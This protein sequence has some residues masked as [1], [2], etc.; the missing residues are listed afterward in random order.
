M[1][2]A[3]E[4]YE[5][6]AV[7]HA[8]SALEPEDE[9]RFLAHLPG[10]AA[11]ERALA[12][13]T[14]TLAH[15]A[16][17][18]APAEPPASLLEGIRSG[19]AASGRA[20][21]FPAPASLDAARVRRRDRTVRWTTAVLGAAAA[22]VLVVALV[23]VNRGLSSREHDAQVANARLS[24]AVSSLLVSGARRV[25]LAGHGD[26]KAVAVLH[27]STVSLVVAGLP[28]NDRSNSVYVLWEK[29]RFGDVRAVGTFDVRSKALAVV[30]G[31]HL[32]GAPSELSTLMVTREH[33]RSAPAL[34][35]Q[36]PLVAGD[37]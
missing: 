21:D 2:A 37:V 29:S 7:G 33:G 8:L 5:Q 19:V 3:H 6:L 1:N 30:N 26:T 13:H 22:V 28:E 9:Q 27:G 23:F 32:T 36:S 24:Q 20:G 16:Y 31:L 34:T 25:D 11:C 12:E 17:A 14:E 35:T 4:L 18:T 10:C 15:L